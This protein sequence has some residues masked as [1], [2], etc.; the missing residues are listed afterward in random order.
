[1]NLR[2]KV[3][4]MIVAVAGGATAA[5]VA[6]F[7][8]L[9]Y[10]SQLAAEQERRDSVVAQSAHM[11]G[12]AQLANDPLMLI[13]YARDLAKRREVLSARVHAGGAW[14]DTD[15]SNAA[16]DPR[17]DIVETASLPGAPGVEVELHFSRSESERRL[18]AAY[19]ALLADAAR[20]GG[21]A[22]VLALLVAFP[23][24][25]ALTRRVLAIEKALA[26]IGGG[27]LDT[28]LPRLGS[29]EIGR[30][31]AGVNVMAERL[32][33]LERLKKTF[34]ASVTH[35]LR[36]PLGAIEGYVK[37]L[38]DRRAGL[39]DE[40]RQALVRI[41][42][43]A[44]RLGHFVT[45]MLDMAKIERGKL[46]YAP[47][48]VD[49]GEIVADT[50]SFFRPKAEEAGLALSAQVEP[51]LPATRAD[52]DLVAHVLTNL[53]SNALKFTRP[54]GKVTVTLA[55]SAGGL[56]LAV[57]DTGI[58]LKS[59][60]AARIFRP[61]ERVANPLRATGVGLGLAISRKIAEMHKG[62][63]GVASEPGRGS[64]FHLRLPCTG[65]Q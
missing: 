3:M 35:E 42:N 25:A 7:A 11:I 13:D 1:M 22:A 45:N 5:C 30:L 10:R 52:P 27:E 21:L 4:L 14:T 38:L 34:V 31:G 59:E 46:D 8:S 54:G 55:R 24:S 56:E 19:E 40:E 6:A 43:N 41:E 2:A 61:F 9:E 36:S 63:L 47:R 17:G 29:D 50:V 51:N 20:A 65:A 32:S 49:V 39:S 60:D 53:I 16:A 64:R 12:E 15:A 33:E 18:A 44:R 26:D 57:S 58:G 37:S 48:L 23:L 62:E 28:R